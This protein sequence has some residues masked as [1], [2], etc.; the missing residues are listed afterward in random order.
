M[1]EVSDLAR[2][3]LEGRRAKDYTP[4]L[5]YLR[6][7]T[8]SKLDGE[9]RAMQVQTLPHFEPGW[10][11]IR[12]Q[13]GCLCPNL[14]SRSVQALGARYLLAFSPLHQSHSCHGELAVAVTH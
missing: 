5:S 10:L 6:G 11:L 3:L 1:G 4:L 14:L 8:P 9:L 2:L 13:P 7:I 12:P